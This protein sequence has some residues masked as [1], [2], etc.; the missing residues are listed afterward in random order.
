ML[1]RALEVLC[2]FAGTIF[3]EVF[4]DVLPA[5]LQV[6]FGLV[7]RLSSSGAELGRPLTFKYSSQDAALEDARVLA[8]ACVCLGALYRALG[9]RAMGSL[10][11]LLVVFKRSA[12]VADGQESFGPSSKLGEGSALWLGESALRGMLAIAE[13]TPRLLG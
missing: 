3:P 11:E 10:P 1:L 7:R 13:S 6:S 12:A 9:K 5:A 2:N 8:Y 4:Q